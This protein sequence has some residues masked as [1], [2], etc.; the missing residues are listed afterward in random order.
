M[1]IFWRSSIIDNMI[2]LV[3]EP[4]IQPTHNQTTGNPKMVT[5]DGMKLFHILSDRTLS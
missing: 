2:I 4:P 5:K 1:M 3:V